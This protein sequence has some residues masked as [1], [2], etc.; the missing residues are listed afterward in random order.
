MF[1]DFE[2]MALFVQEHAIMMRKLGSPAQLARN[3]MIESV[4]LC[5][6]GRFAESA[7]LMEEAMVIDDN[8]GNRALMSHFRIL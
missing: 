3:L 5:Y 2:K 6:L 4:N 7:R 8:L 1:G